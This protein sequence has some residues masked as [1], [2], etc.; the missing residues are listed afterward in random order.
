MNQLKTF[1]EEIS[2][3]KVLDVG[4]GTGRFTARLRELFPSAQIVG[5]DPDQESLNQA[6]D[7]LPGVDFRWMS[8]E[9][10]LFADQTFDVAAISMV[11]HHLKDVS[12]V[13]AEMKRVI[14]HNGYLLVVELVAD[15]LE[16]DQEV[17][18]GFHH[19]RSKI[20]R[21][22]GVNH[23]ETMPRNMI[24]ELVNKAGFDVVLQG[25]LNSSERVSD[26]EL[27]QI[28]QKLEERLK[29]IQHSPEYPKLRGEFEQ[30]KKLA[31]QQGYRMAPC[32]VLVGTV[33][34]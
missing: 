13:L 32:V 19:L 33:A 21:L 34:D 30:L 17:Q 10:L 26:D 2:I 14:T 4:C 20:D 22:L 6:K 3:G 9:N 23:F 7:V 8:G 27:T 12:A 16:A 5:V 15:N 11:L 18:K 31:L 1:F 25:E 29:D 24:V 28:F